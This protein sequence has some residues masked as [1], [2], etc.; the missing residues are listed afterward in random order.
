MIMSLSPNIDSFLKAQTP[1]VVN[2][3]TIYAFAVWVEQ[4]SLNPQTGTQH[5][6]PVVL[7]DGVLLVNRSAKVIRD[8]S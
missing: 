4:S 3:E 8:E 6:Y 7:R 5:I 2:P 1:G